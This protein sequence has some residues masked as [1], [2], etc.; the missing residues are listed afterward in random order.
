M[1]R[2]LSDAQH[3]EL[4]ELHADDPP[5]RKTKITITKLKLIEDEF[6]FWV[7][8]TVPHERGVVVGTHIYRLNLQGQLDLNET[9]G[10]LFTT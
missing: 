4:V 1:M 3:A 2:V 5:P 6:E 10:T 8:F 7:E 9:H